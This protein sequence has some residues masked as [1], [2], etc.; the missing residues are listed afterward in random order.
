MMTSQYV[1]YIFNST[2]MYMN[3][4]LIHPYGCKIP[5]NDYYEHRLDPS[6][7]WLGWQWPPVFTTLRDYCR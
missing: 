1:F 2:C 6:M 3:H 5:I 4:C 7:N